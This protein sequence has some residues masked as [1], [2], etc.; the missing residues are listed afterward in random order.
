MAK[1]AALYLEH[2]ADRYRYLDFR[3]MGVANR[4]PLR[5]LLLDVYI[6]MRARVEAPEGETWATDAPRQPPDD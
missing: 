3:G 1:A 4:T 5:L 6:P 2:L